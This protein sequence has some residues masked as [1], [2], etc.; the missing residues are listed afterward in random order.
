[1]I[2]LGLLKNYLGIEVK[3]MHDHIVISKEKDA[4]QFLQRFKIKNNK[5]APTPIEIGLKLRK[6]DCIK[7]V[8][9]TLYKSMVGSLMYLTATWP[10]IIMH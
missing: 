2:Y 7:S 9:V 6:E 1:M 5:I 8:N 10:N 3:Q 4:T